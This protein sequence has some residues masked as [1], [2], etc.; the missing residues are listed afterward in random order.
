MDSLC[1]HAGLSLIDEGAMHLLPLEPYALQRAVQ[2]ML[3]RWGS[4]DAG[5]EIVCVRD[6][7]M[8]ALNAEHMGRNGKVAEVVDRFAQQ[9]AA[10]RLVDGD[11]R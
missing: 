1:P 7:A 6:C 8:A 11:L 4:P 10:I 9:V 5:M 2:A 3:E